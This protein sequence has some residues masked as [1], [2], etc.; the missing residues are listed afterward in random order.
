MLGFDTVFD[1]IMYSYAIQLKR[2]R[3]AAVAGLH[4][5]VA[6]HRLFH[7]LLSLLP[8]GCGV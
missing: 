3:E 6:D 2:N 7:G 4:D 5:S 8:L 1:T